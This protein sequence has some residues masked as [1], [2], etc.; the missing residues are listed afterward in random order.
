MGLILTTGVLKT[1]TQIIGIEPYLGAGAPYSYAWNNA[2]SPMFDSLYALG[3]NIIGWTFYT[4]SNPGSS[5]TITAIDPLGSF[6]LSF[7]GDPGAGPY[8]AQSPDYAVKSQGF[9]IGPGVVLESPPPPKIISTGLR[10]YLDAG[11]PTSYPGTGSTWTDLIT[12]RAFTLYNNPAYSSDHG[13]C[14]NFVAANEQY[15][16]APSLSSSLSNWTVEA[17]HYYDGTSYILD[18]GNSP[19]IITE[20]YSGGGPINYTLGNC[21]DSFPNLQAGWFAGDTFFQT[22]QGYVLTAG[23]WYHLVGILDGNT[24]RL[25]INGVQVATASAASG[26]LSP[27]QGIRL[28]RRW[29]YRNYWGGKLAVVRIYGNA[30]TDADVLHNFKVE[31][32]R[33]GI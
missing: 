32:S 15:A 27:G 13:G 16:Q 11:N 12:S 3:S 26:G 14:I 6:S 25:Y 29:D 8:T 2:T 10:L 28:M 20:V 22:P 21:S 4:T 19:C 17:W 24:L 31:H 30:L 5:V 18:G 9:T 33:F 23:Q 1:G 7:S